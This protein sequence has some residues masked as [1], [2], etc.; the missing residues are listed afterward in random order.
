[1]VSRYGYRNGRLLIKTLFLSDVNILTAYSYCTPCRVW[2]SLP[3]ETSFCK[4]QKRQRLKIS[5]WVKLPPI[6]GLGLALQSI[7]EIPNGCD[8]NCSRYVLPSHA[9]CVASVM[10]VSSASSSLASPLG[11]RSSSSPSLLAAGVVEEL[12]GIGCCR[13]GTSVCVSHG[14]RR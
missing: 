1:M 2:P 14:G 13:S 8:L 4:P 9:Q 12:G 7:T 10:T 11:S 6:L 5:S 3:A